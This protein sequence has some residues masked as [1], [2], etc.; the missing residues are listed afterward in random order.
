[1]GLFAGLDKDKYDRQYSDRY[2]F[3]R[4]WSYFSRYK[5]RLSIIIATGLLTAAVSASFPIIIAS[6]VGALED[7]APTSTLVLLVGALFVTQ[8]SQHF[9]NRVR[10]RM[11][12]R[13][14]AD[15]TANLRRDALASA[16]HRDMAFYDTNKSGKVLSRIT[17]DTEEFGQVLVITSDI[18]TQLTQALVLLVVLLSRNVLLS[19]AELAFLPLILIVSTVPQVRPHRHSPRLPRDGSRQRPDSG[20][21]HRDH[22]RQELPAGGDDLRGILR[23]QP[24]VLPRQH[25]ARLC[26]VAGLPG[27]ECGRGLRYRRG[28]VYW[29]DN[30]HARRDPGAGMVH[31]H[32]VRR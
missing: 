7:N 1:M 23:D 17:S 15:L 19:L 31:V 14:V 28:A 22:R 21:R 10:R 27:A 6:G 26:A 13:L 9:S 8:V 12:S 32:P 18:V 29:G 20:E 4:L 5:R 25:A 16:V 2:L 11:M 24:A 30:R 3:R